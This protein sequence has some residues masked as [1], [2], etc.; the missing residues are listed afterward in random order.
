MALRPGP[1]PMSADPSGCSDKYYAYLERPAEESII[2]EDGLSTPLAAGPRLMDVLDRFGAFHLP[3]LSTLPTSNTKK[4]RNAL[5]DEVLRGE[6]VEGD[7][8]RLIERRAL[9]MNPE[10]QRIEDGWVEST[11]KYNARHREQRLWERLD[12]HRSQLEAH[13]AT[14]ERL[15]MRH[16]S[17]LRLVEEA[18][19]IE[20]KG[21]S[22]A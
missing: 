3:A 17:G 6:I 8:D 9:K 5:I 16:K 10:Q 19:G 18:L 15:I 13:T 7:L 21:D 11:R 20:S 14:F 22:A 4:A 12:Y 2:L 1:S